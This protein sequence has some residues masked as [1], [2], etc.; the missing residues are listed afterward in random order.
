MTARLDSLGDDDVNAGR[1]RSLRVYYG[2]DLMEDLHSCGVGRLHI[3][4]RVTPE[5][6]ED[7]DALV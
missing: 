5:Q 2:P 4:R 7:G 3:R 1:R 6:R